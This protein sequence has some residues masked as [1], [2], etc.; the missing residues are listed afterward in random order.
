MKTLVIIIVSA[1]LAAVAAYHFAS[2]NNRHAAT[3]DSAI[4]AAPTDTES[5]QP[6]PSV[7]R[8]A[9]T[10]LKPADAN[11]GLDSASTTGSATHPG[12]AA[13]SQ[14]TAVSSPVFTQMLEI[15][16]SPQMSYQKKQEAWA[17][18]RDSGKLD[19]TIADLERRAAADPNSA[20]YPAALGQACLQKAGTIQDLREQG[21]LG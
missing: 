10:Q 4:A 11:P 18:L 1:S 2:R 20:A 12:G 14:S 5:Q 7:K 13:A 19:Q 16:V 15:L 9:K 21:I 8:A 3:P 17:Q 6:S